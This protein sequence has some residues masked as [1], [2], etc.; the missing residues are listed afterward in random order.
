MIPTVAQGPVFSLGWYDLI[1]TV[2]GL[3]RAEEV[4]PQNLGA[5]ALVQHQLGGGQIGPDL[6]GVDTRQP[7]RDV[8]QVD[9]ESLAEPSV[10]VN[11]R[12]HL[13]G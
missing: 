12:D 13:C 4:V 5:V 9:D 7:Q 6:G 2:A 3:A 8:V 1:G 10:W 11:H